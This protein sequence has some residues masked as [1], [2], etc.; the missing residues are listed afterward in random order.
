M[1]SIYRKA[2]EGNVEIELNKQSQ[3]LNDFKRMSFFLPNKEFYINILEVQNEFLL[4]KSRKFIDDRGTLNYTQSLKVKLQTAIDNQ[5]KNDQVN[6]NM[7]DAEQLIL[8]ISKFENDFLKKA[9]NDSIEIER[10]AQMLKNLRFPEQFGSRRNL[11]V[12]K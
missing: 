11:K 12:E 4:L 1:N 7:R 2:F 9:I 8:S 10:R 6:S 5:T 3:I